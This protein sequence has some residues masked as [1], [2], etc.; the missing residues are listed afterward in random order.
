MLVFENCEFSFLFICAIL[1]KKM[2]KW[3]TKNKKKKQNLWGTP[4]IPHF[5]GSLGVP[6]HGKNGVHALSVTKRFC[7]PN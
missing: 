2:Q 3:A 7:R 6:E 1:V 4:T 5:F